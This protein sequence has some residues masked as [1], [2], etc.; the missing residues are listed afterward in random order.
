MCHQMWCT[1]TCTHTYT[2]THTHVHTPTDSRTRTHTLHACTH[3]PLLPVLVILV[4]CGHFGQQISHLESGVVNLHTDQVHITLHKC[5]H[6]LVHSVLLLPTI[7]QSLPS[8][9]PLS[10]VSPSQRYAWSPSIHRVPALTVPSSPPP[11]SPSSNP[12]LPPSPSLPP[13]PPPPPLPPPL[14]PF[15][16]PNLLLKPLPLRDTHSL[17]HFIGRHLFQCR[18][19]HGC[20]R[21]HLCLQL[22]PVSSKLLHLL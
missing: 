13:P 3:S 6:N 14:P 16:P 7:H 18:L 22:L 1:R 12:S 11:P 21:L 2:H 15:L 9:Q 17:L 4:Q 19:V 10:E 5:S 8:S 20:E